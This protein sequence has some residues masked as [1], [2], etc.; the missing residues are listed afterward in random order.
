[1]GTQ[2]NFELDLLIDGYIS[3]TFGSRDAETYH[4]SLLGRNVQHIQWY[5]ILPESPGIFFAAPPPPPATE[6]DQQRWAIDYA[7]KDTGLVVP[8][9]I[10]A[11]RNSADAQRYVHNEQLRPPVFFVHK[12]GRSLGLPLIDASGGNCLSLRSADQPA[13]LGPSSHAQIRI[14]VSYIS[15]FVARY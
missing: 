2:Q 6:S 8:Q 14:N 11:P 15:A 5:T 4:A 7:V 10:W 3:H 9:Q 1:M 13:G 12:D